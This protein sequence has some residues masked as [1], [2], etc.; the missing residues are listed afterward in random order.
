MH[1]S[2]GTEIFKSSRGA[3][4]RMPKS[5]SI[6]DLLLREAFFLLVSLSSSSMLAFKSAS[7]GRVKQLSSLLDSLS[8]ESL[9]LQVSLYEW[10]NSATGSCLNLKEQEIVQYSEKQRDNQRKKFQ[11]KTINWKWRIILHCLREVGGLPIQE[12]CQNNMIVNKKFGIC[13]PAIII[14]IQLELGSKIL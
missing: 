13:D 11:T 3:K 8:D 1:S 10:G 7:R 6:F 5:S 4:S 12:R 9:M 2:S 14:Y